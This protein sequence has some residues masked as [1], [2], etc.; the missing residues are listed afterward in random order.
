MR[1][2]RPDLVF[3][4]APSIFAAP[5]AAKAARAVGAA[6]WLHF[7]DFEIAAAFKLNLVAGKR[8]QRLAERFEAR[9]INSFDRVSSISP[10]MIDYL[11]EKRDDQRAFELRNWVDTRAIAP[12]NRE[13]A[14]RDM[15]GLTK[16][17]IVVLYSGSMSVKQGLEYVIE[18]AKE[19]SNQKSSKI[20]FVFCGA[21]PM[22]EQLVGSAASVRNMRLLELQP[23]SKLSDL[24]ATADIHL[25]PQL[26]EVADLVLPSKLGGIFASG[27]PVIAMA[28]QGTQ[29]ASEINGAGLAIAPADTRA[30]IAAISHLADNPNARLKLGYAAR[31]IALNRLDKEVILQKFERDLL[32][33]VQSGDKNLPAQPMPKAV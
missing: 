1:K 29:L 8:M 25:I 20:I 11:S 19:L 17:D 31:E 23:A 9:I 27:R 21:G 33:L 18:A 6:S 14:F 26:P 16:D 10:K 13:T 28:N 3:S 15:L 24:F 22:R 32:S 12:R 2:I 5:V 4:I 7:H 30:L